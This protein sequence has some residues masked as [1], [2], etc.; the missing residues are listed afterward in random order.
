MRHPGQTRTAMSSISRRTRH[1]AGLVTALTA[2]SMLLAACGGSDSSSG[3][4]SKSITVGGFDIAA[5]SSLYYASEKGYFKKAGLDVKVKTLTAAEFVP[6]VTSQQVNVSFGSVPAVFL[7]ASKNLPVTMLFQQL[8]TSPDNCPQTL[9]VSPGSSIK[10][11]ADLKG[12]TIAIDS[13]NSAE[14]LALNPI[15]EHNGIQPSEVKYIPVGAVGQ[16]DLAAVQKGT[17]D[18]M[19]QTEPFSTSMQ[20]SG[21]AR[22]ITNLCVSPA[23]NPLNNSGYFTTPKYLS[24]NKASIKLFEQAMVDVTK[25]INAHPDTFNAWLAKRFKAPVKAMAAQHLGT[26]G[27]YDRKDSYIYLQKAMVQ[28]GLPVSDVKISD[29]N[30]PLLVTG[31]DG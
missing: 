31:S 29:I 23:P 28:V 10:T 4:S 8:A 5:G 17:A 24:S 2:A 30:S 1:A 22:L 6:A 15:L 12:K 7:A 18:A 21:D 25:D 11:I 16:P 3:S 13:Q 27:V 9:L 20:A 26:F 19:V 14:E